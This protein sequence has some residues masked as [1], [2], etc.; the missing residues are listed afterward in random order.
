MR[1]LPRRR[2]LALGIA[3]CAAFAT[4]CAT[5]SQIAALSQVD[6]SID[7]ATD[8][9]LAGIDIASKRSYRDLTPSEAANLAAALAR[10]DLPLRF[11]L[12]LRAENPVDNPV[13]ARLIRMEWTMLLEQR[14]TVSGTLEREYVFPPGQ[15]QDVPIVISLDLLDFF[16]RNAQDL[17]DLARNLAGAGGAPKNIALRARPTIETPIGPIAYPSPITIVS[18]DVGR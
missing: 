18:R 9:R 2:L 6:F 4:G 8:V 11:D 1:A 12:H 16:D 3:L 10:G 15:P 7:R 17:F 14:E 5:L 13:S